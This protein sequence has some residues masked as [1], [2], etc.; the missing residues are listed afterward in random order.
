MN[1]FNVKMTQRKIYASMSSSLI[2][3]DS[4]YKGAV[5]H[6]YDLQKLI[7]FNKDYADVY[8]TNTRWEFLNNTWTDTGVSIPYNENL[9]ATELP[10]DT[11]FEGPRLGDSKRFALEDHVHKQIHDDTKVDVTEFE[12]NVNE[13]DAK[14][15]AETQRAQ[16]AEARLKQEID[17]E[18]TRAEQA[19]QILKEYAEAETANREAADAELTNKINAEETARIEGDNTNSSA[20]SAEKTRAE[21]AENELGTRIT[22]ETSRATTAEGV[23]ADSI[24]EESSR[25]KLAEQTNAGKIETNKSSIDAIKKLIP[26]A[27]TE[28]NKLADKDFVNSSIANNASNYVTSTPSGDSQFASLAALQAGPWYLRG[29]SYTPTKNDYAIYINTDN[30]VWRAVYDGQL[31]V[32]AYKVN[33]TPFT[34]DQIAAL[35]S[36]VTASLLANM[37]NE[38][39]NKVVMTALASVLYGTDADGNQITK[40]ISDFATALQGQKADTAY[41]KPASGI[42]ES[43]LAATIQ[44][45]LALARTAL[46]SFIEQDP[47]VPEWAKQ[48][49]KPTYTAEEVGALPNTTQYVSSVNGKS[50]AI[51]DIATQTEVDKKVDKTSVSESVVANSVVK[52]TIDGDILVNDDNTAMAS[53]PSN[54]AVSKGYVQYV[55]TTLSELIDKDLDAVIS[56]VS[57]SASVDGYTHTLTF[58]NLNN[59]GIGTLDVVIPKTE[60][61]IV[62]DSALFKY[63]FTLKDS[64]GNTLSTKT[65]DLPL[66]ELVV[67]GSY[68]NVTKS[69]VL[70]LKNGN[71]VDIPV[72]D[73]IEG[74]VTSTDLQNAL[75]DYATLEQVNAKYTKPNTGIPKTDLDSSVQASLGKADTA[76]QEHQSL[77]N[78]A[79]KEEVNTAK[80]SANSYTDTKTGEISTALQQNTTKIN[81][82]EQ[83]NA[84][85][86]S[87]IENLGQTDQNMQSQI[88][89]LKKLYAVGSIYMSVNSTSPAE[90]FGGT[91]ERIKDRFLLGSG[92]SYSAGATGGSASVTLTGDNLPNILQV[93]QNNSGVTKYISG[94]GWTNQPYADQAFIVTQKSYLNEVGNN[95]I[96]NQPHENMPPYL[97]VYIWKRTA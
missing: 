82:L 96:Y 17:N 31:W 26:N 37:T 63:T 8:E 39:A 29:E 7:A 49:N 24:D 46:Q 32:A 97:A 27:A 48:E 69:I 25:A 83:Q 71:T 42:P 61:E 66:E 38:I 94:C 73:L 84:S 60:L 53:K 36:G 55:V 20:I 89:V 67:D 95:Y 76:L 35:N 40:A 41:Q 18:N 3:S 30:S 72:G 59:I 9:R 77:A 64:K 1:K 91:W 54:V 34:A 19:E 2:R 85:Q 93:G 74:L 52:R 62:E 22:D 23:L 43:D 75:S 80:Q 16:E 28:D 15:I 21:N 5:E 13:L 50:G 90:L 12:N 51:T 33:D 65:I 58:K 68:D 78:Y 45:A 14:I 44:S 10:L 81:E 6:I 70:T 86:S 92:D 57:S 11:S 88:D 47:T 4:S 87:Q 56:S 79:T